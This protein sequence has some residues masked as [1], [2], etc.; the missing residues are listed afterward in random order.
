MEHKGGEEHTMADWSA[1]WIARQDPDVEAGMMRLE[2]DLGQK[3][4]LL[5]EEEEG[6][7]TEEE[8]V[9]PLFMQGLPKDFT[10]NTGLAAL[11]SLLEEEEEEEVTTDKKNKAP[12]MSLPAPTSR[13]GKVSRAKSRK[14]RQ[15]APYQVSPKKN[16]QAASL[17][18]AQLF[19]KMWKL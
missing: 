9:C 13:G 6:E 12:K 19:M 16:K 3:S 11:A 18:E 2:N 14:Q 5:N 15:N 4:S 10:K 8:V 7:Q 17:G 1:K